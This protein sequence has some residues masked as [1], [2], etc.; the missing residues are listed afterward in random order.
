MTTSA[1]RNQGVEYFERQKWAEAYAHLSAADR[2]EAL[3]AEILE[4]LGTAAYLVGREAEAMDLLVRVHNEY[5]NRG[6]TTQAVRA[7]FWLGFALQGKGEH[8]RAGGWISRGRRLLDDC[9][10]C[11]EQGYMMLPP[12]V[13][14]MFSGD[15][16]AAL[17]KF[18]EIGRI[19][20]RFDDNDLITMARMCQGQALIRLGQSAAGVSLFDEVMVAVTTG[21]VAPAFSGLIYCAV[22][23]TCSDI[24]DLRRAQEW[25]GA[26][27]HW[28][29][30]HPDMVP[31]R[32]QCLVRRAEIMQLQGEWQDAMLEAQRARETLADRGERAVGAAL[33]QVAELHRL[34]GEFDK[35]EEAYRQASEWGRKTQPGMARLRLAQGQ[36]DAAKS[37]IQ[38][39]VDETRD[40]SRP[41]MLDA[42]V[43]IMLEAGDVNAARRG[44]AE[45]SD[46]AASLQ[47]PY[48]GAVAAQAEGAVLLAE[49]SPRD[50]LAA[51]RRAWT[52]WGELAAPYDIARATVCIGLACRAL[53]DDD[54]AD[55]ELSAAQR[56]FETL[57]AKP[58]AA[59]VARLREKPE[60]KAMGGLTG[61]EIE[62]LRLVAA[63]K[64]NRAIADEL[65][66]S[67]KTIARHVSNIFMKLG[68][69]TRAAATAY[70]YK[71]KLT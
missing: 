9:Q 69:S 13:Q 8:A 65:G 18:I 61:R 40:E 29:A 35:A 19:A 12:A 20:E 52:A 46:I 4:R 3:P 21:E 34:R 23:E 2:E 15:A 59:R 11:V 24:F 48:L 39:V 71:H 57:G 62:V 66:I 44:S 27:S 1:A 6:Q 33:Y 64:T 37:S 56:A 25:T 14:T 68:L 63:G 50:A 45:L 10:D 51:L 30:S 28:C 26:L 58:D 55:L 31:Y 36:I 43:D 53:G 60:A 22:I 70:A 49:G 5:L 17:E 7:A 54:T 16:A 47:S 38:R 67:E 41:R 32:G 42:F